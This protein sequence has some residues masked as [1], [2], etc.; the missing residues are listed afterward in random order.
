M[1]T[2]EEQIVQAIHVLNDYALQGQP[3]HAQAFEFLNKLRAE[4]AHSWRYAL[5]LFV[6]TN[7]DGRTR[8]YGPDVRMFAL[9]VL[10]DFLEFR[11]SSGNLP[12]E[13][14]A[15]LRE[16][17]LT[18][19][20]M[21]YLYGPAEGSANYIRNKFSLTLTL[22]FLVSYEKQWSTFFDD[23]FTL[24]KPPP[25]SGAEPFNK[26]VS[27]FFFRLV[28]EI[29]SEVA[30]QVLKNARAFSAERMARD[31]RIRDLIRSNEAAKINTA[32]LAIV[33]EGKQT[34]D[35]QRAE[36][37]DAIIAP[38]DEEVVDTGIRAFASYV[39][40][41]D[42]NLTVTPDSIPLL[43]SLLADPDLAIRLATCTALQK[44]VTKGLKVAS[45]KLK[46]LQVLSLTPVID[47]LEAQ[48]LASRAVSPGD[49]LESFREALARIV[50]ALGIELKEICANTTLPPDEMQA[51]AEMLIELVPLVLRF[52]ADKFDDTSY[53]YKKERSAS[54]HSH[55]TAQREEF[56]RATLNILIEKFKWDS[57]D[58]PEDTDSEDVSYF[59]N[60]RKDIRK[61]MDSIYSI[62]PELVTSIISERAQSALDSYESGAQLPWEEAELAIFLVF[63]FGELG[64]KDR[65][66][67]RLAFC[68]APPNIPKEARKTIDYSEYP[69]T[70]QGEMMQS[71]LRSRISTYPNPTVA[72]QFF[73]TVARYADFFKVRKENVLPALEAFLDTRGVHHPVMTVRRRVFYLFHRFVQVLRI[74]IDPQ[75]VPAILTAIQDLLVIDAKIPDD[76]S[77]NE[78]EDFLGQLLKETTLF[79]AQLYIFEAAG[80]LVS[81]LWSMPEAQAVTLQNLIAPLLTHLSACLQK[82]PTGTEEDH[83]NALEVHHS[84]CALGNIPKG[85]P[86]YPSPVPPDYIQPPIAEFRQMAEAILVSLGVMGHLK[87][88][89]EAARFAFGRLIAAA[90]PTITEYVPRL[91]QALLSHFETTEFVDFISFIA[92]MTHKLQVQMQ[93]VLDEVFIPLTTHVS[94]LIAQPITGTDD[95]TA[96][97][98]TKKA[99]LTFLNTVMHSNLGTIFISP[100]N[101]PNL[102]AF[103]DTILQ[104]AS[105]ATDPLNQKLAL[106]FINRFISSFGQSAPLADS[107]APNSNI[108]VPGIEQYIYQRIFVTAFNIPTAPDFNM[109]DGQST[110][111]LYEIAS[112]FQ[113]TVKVR[114]DEAVNYLATVFL[115]SQNLT[116][117]M[118]AELVGNMQSMDKRGF[119]KYY[120]DLVK[121][122]RQ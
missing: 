26:H 82:P 21:E 18:Y 114:G 122:Y 69:L 71:L 56:L 54:P 102:Q 67:G 62:N 35:R 10:N 16:Q 70:P 84:I 88:I 113:T 68:M 60:M 105:D 33:L 37:P 53:V 121:A 15:L 50:N 91:M 55:M 90:G 104:M 89:R 47:Q 83:Q 23:I 4:S 85:F 98:D 61:L 58:D 22:L 14:V 38:L 25:E 28:L 95:K 92:H 7:D 24:L 75:N 43:F 52:L 101:V 42:I 117:Q 106:T 111:T 119:Q 11:N 30:D 81:I 9:N 45:D 6:A 20:R 120:T 5:S 64:A 99:Y 94:S 29:S 74:D 46:L 107:A 96:H 40:W 79:D 32:V 65:G 48:T 116:P 19:L 51:A 66:K 115:P 109:K 12:D 34:I 103:L 87:A 49:D 44:I 93:P 72:M 1:S 118:A 17:L 76:F 41:I 13:D 27:I 3:I 77:H 80:A 97:I 86:E 8:R 59:E 112:I 36:N 78:G 110:A 2:P 100:R 73:E 39:P 57:E 31:G 108:V 63:M